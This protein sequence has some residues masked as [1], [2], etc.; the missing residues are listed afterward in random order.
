MKPSPEYS[1]EPPPGGVAGTRLAKV[2]V[3]LLATFALALPTS[4][5]S[6]KVPADFFGIFAEGPIEKDFKDMGDAGFGTY[7]VPINWSSIQQTRDGDYAWGQSDYGIYNA[8]KNGMRPVP[9][10]YGTPRFVHK[11]ADGLYPPT[12]K[13][14]LRE[15]KDFTQ[16]LA[17]RYSPNG[18]YFDAVPEIDQLPVKTWILWNEQNSK[19]NWLPKAD[20]REYARVVENGA[21]GISKVDPKAE[22]VLGGMYGYPRD[23][24]S[25]K[26]AKYLKKLY[27]VDGIE[28]H[29][30]AVNAHPY[31]PDVASVKSQVGDLLSVMSKAGDG[32]AGMYLG[33]L[34]WASTGPS[35]SESV[36]GRKG[37]AKR[38]RD[39]LNLLVKKR[40]AWN[41]GGVFVYVW[42][43]FPDGQLACLWCA[44]AGLV[45]EDGKAKPALDAVQK[46]MAKHG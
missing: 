23:P 26:A 39:G 41:L 18:D 37:Q 35:R 38:L 3:A 36:V 42:R 29:F 46:V 44:G 2:V 28:K 1:S 21:E 34:G 13:A 22:I 45:E 30:D 19:S 17:A 11:P 16:A 6:A 43:D 15:W 14:D 32:R 20:P 9:V 24:K 5:A 27:G 7:R 25:M 33:E 8:A 40:N 4:G 31:G 12:S 10:V